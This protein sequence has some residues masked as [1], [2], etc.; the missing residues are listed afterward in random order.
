[1]NHKEPQIV[2]QPGDEKLE[3]KMGFVAC[4][5]IADFD[6]IRAFIQTRKNVRLVRG[7]MSKERLWL[8]KDK[9]FEALK[10]L[11]KRNA[12]GEKPA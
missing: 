11:E 10:T 12:G 1:M 3:I 8:V 5:N 2:L 4:G 9:E 7:T 6:A